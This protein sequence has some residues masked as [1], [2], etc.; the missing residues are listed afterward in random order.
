MSSVQACCHD[1]LADGVA[2]HGDQLSEH[3]RGGM[4][5]GRAMGREGGIVGVDLGGSGHLRVVRGPAGGVQERP[6]L[7][8]C[9][10]GQRFQGGKV[11]SGLALSDGDAGQDRD[12][13]HCSSS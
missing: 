7:I 13:W 2:G 4:D 10:L 5:L 8:P 6:G 11:R 12:L 1:G 9:L 3:Q